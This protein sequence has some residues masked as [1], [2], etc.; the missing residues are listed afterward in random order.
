MTFEFYTC[1]AD[2]F[3]GSWRV[4]APDR[5][6]A[7]GLIRDSARMSDALD[8]GSLCEPYC[9][10]LSAVDGRNAEATQDDWRFI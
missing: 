2:G 7:E 1:D 9:L 8:E 6:T 5:I 4:E 10:V 3:W